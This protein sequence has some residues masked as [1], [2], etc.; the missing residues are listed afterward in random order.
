MPTRRRLANLPRR[1]RRIAMATL[2]LWLATLCLAQAPANVARPTQTIDI[3]GTSPL[4]GQGIAR[5]ELPYTT[6]VL[7]RRQIEDAQAVNTTDLL[8]RRVSAAQ[9]NDIQGS[10]FQGDLTFRGYRASGLLGA[11][12][13]LSVHLDGVRM[14]EPFGD[15]VNWDLLPE[16]AIESLSLVP[17]ANPAFGLNTLGGAIAIGTATGRSA[18][19]WRAEASGGSFGRRRADL[20][21]GWAGANRHAFVSLSLF[22]EKGWRDFSGGR[23][24]HLVAKA[25]STPKRARSP[26]AC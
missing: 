13:G 9:V 4:P 3:I 12:Q 26:P 5:D 6:L 18:P 24:G 20:S 8:A 14:N 16:F 2:S 10:P 21:H 19:G 7:L 17:G 25:G 11:G 15:V 22:D 1:T 23:L